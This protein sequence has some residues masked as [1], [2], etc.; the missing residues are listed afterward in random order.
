MGND[1]AEYPESEPLDDLKRPTAVQELATTIT[2][3]NF[4]KAAM[5]TNFPTNKPSASSS[6]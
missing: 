3:F 6:N 2:H 5:L 1:I 4:L